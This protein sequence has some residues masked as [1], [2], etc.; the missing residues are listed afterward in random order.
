[1]AHY[2]GGNK[3]SVFGDF[4]YDVGGTKKDDYILRA[5]KDGV[6]YWTDKDNV[7]SPREYDHFV[8]EWFGGGVVVAVWVENGIDKCLVVAPTDISYFLSDTTDDGSFNFTTTYSTGRVVPWSN[9][10]NFVRPYAST[11]TDV[12]G[13]TV[14][15]LTNSNDIV[16]TVGFSA[17]KN[18]NRYNGV[19]SGFSGAASW[20]LDYVNPNLGTGVYNDWYLPALHE[21]RALTSNLATVNSVLSQYATDNEIQTFDTGQPWQFNPALHV[22]AKISSV[23][24]TYWTSTWTRRDDNTS[25]SVWYCNTDME[26]NYSDAYQNLTGPRYATASSKTTNYFKVRPFR[27]AD[28]S[29]VPF[30]FDGDWAI[31]TYVFTKENDLD[32]RTVLVTPDLPLSSSGYNQNNYERGWIPSSAGLAAPLSTTNGL[33][34]A[35]GTYSILWHAS[36]QT[37]LGRETVLVNFNAFR[38]FYPTTTEMIVDMRAHWYTNNWSPSFVAGDQGRLNATA[39][40]SVSIMLYKGGT[41]QLV[42]DSNNKLQWTLN[43]WT[44]RQQL[45]SMSRV[46][47]AAYTSPTSARRVAL[48]KYNLVTKSGMVYYQ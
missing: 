27:I 48:L 31:I 41:P 46:I 3:F 34:V 40:V 15:G 44:S 19:R 9:T 8:G 38:N 13:T 5:G 2:F 17:T 42:L 23:D 26:I 14:F 45:S 4:E 29:Q 47:N 6:A 10:E 25:E 12:S 37:G 7:V 32:T 21:F 30:I 18:P 39:P 33:N 36:D 35:N 43:D 22:A 1:M 11:W 20:A 28:D 16:N 24:G